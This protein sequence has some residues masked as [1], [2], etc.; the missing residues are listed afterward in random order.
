MG[1]LEREKEKGETKTN[2]HQASGAQFS[3]ARGT[4]CSRPSS[5]S[6][7]S[8]LISVRL[9]PWAVPACGKLLSARLATLSSS[10]DLP[11]HGGSR[12]QLQPRRAGWF[13]F[14]GQIHSWEKS[15]WIN[16]P[17][18][19]ASDGLILEPLPCLL[20]ACPVG[21]MPRCLPQ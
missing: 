14:K 15:W 12:A 2:S 19:T 5:P 16:H 20:R 6:A 13:A 4:H 8:E 21:L 3:E 1:K 7:S 17:V 18:S 11:K 9:L 10:E